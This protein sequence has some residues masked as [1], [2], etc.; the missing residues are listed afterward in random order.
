MNAILVRFPGTMLVAVISVMGQDSFITI[1]T[2]L[3]FEVQELKYILCAEFFWQSFSAS[4]D[5]LV[6]S[7]KKKFDLDLLILL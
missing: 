1:A 5:V 3:A 6:S 2:P 7:S 4:F